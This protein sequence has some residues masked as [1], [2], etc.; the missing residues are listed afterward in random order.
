MR[1]PAFA[2]TLKF[3]IVAIVVATGVLSAWGTANLLLGVTQSELKRVL[4]AND[5]ASARPDCWPAR[6][7]RSSWRWSKWP[8]TAAATPGMTANRRRL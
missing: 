1:L 4:M 5:R 7:T 2:S 3:R 8:S 6:S